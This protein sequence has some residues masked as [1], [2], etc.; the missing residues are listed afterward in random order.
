M[1][2]PSSLFTRSDVTL[3][4]MNLSSV[5]LAAYSL[6]VLTCEGNHTTLKET[7]AYIWDFVRW[8]GKLESEIIARITV[9]DRTFTSNGCIDSFEWESKVPAVARSIFSPQAYDIRTLTSPEKHQPESWEEKVIADKMICQTHKW[10]RVLNKQSTTK[11]ESDPDQREKVPLR[12]LSSQWNESLTSISTTFG[13]FSTKQ[14][15]LEC[16]SSI[17]GVYI[18]IS[19]QMKVPETKTFGE[20]RGNLCSRPEPANP[21]SVDW[22][23]LWLSC[24][25]QRYPLNLC[26]DSALR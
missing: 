25:A 7:R 11:P 3:R 10:D 17:S 19:E 8:K 16:F 14:W 13:F 15:H 1:T 23:W 24:V 6:S 20:I 4:A 12:T 21:A 9:L 5:G 26:V 18:I 22:S 2:P